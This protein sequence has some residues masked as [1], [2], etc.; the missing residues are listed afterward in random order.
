MAL[1][2]IYL[3]RGGKGTISALHAALGEGSVVQQPFHLAEESSMPTRGAGAAQESDPGWELR[4]SF[5][6][7]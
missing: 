1:S 5:A 6:E 3:S 7:Q 2:L 4:C